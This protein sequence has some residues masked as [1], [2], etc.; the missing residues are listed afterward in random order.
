[1]TMSSVSHVNEGTPRLESGGLTTI[2][3]FGGRSFGVPVAGPT[4]LLHV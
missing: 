1:M 2:P 3:R 4:V